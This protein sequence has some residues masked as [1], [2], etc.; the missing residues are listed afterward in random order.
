M[1][2]EYSPSVWCINPKK[3]KWFIVLWCS[4]TRAAGSPAPMNGAR[5]FGLAT[6][7]VRLARGTVRPAGDTSL[8]HSDWPCHLAGGGGGGSLA[9]R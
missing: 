6:R 4:A 1:N 5:E 9:S 8:L 2:R 7:G 3:C